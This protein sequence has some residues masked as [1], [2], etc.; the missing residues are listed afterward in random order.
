MTLDWWIEATVK[1]VVVFLSVLIASVYLMWVER[2][3]V[4][5]IQSRIG[6]NRVGPQGLLQPIADVIKLITKETVH[7]EA[8]DRRLFL[9]APVFTLVPTFLAF[10]VIP[11]G[12]AITLLGREIQMRPADINV[13]VLLVL[14]LG[15]IGIYGIFLGAWS[16]NNKYALMGGLRTSAQMIS[17]ELIL[18]LAVIAVVIHSGSF[19]LVEIVNAQSKF[20]FV[21]YQ[22]RG[23]A[24]FIIASMAEINRVPFDLPEAE[25]ELVAGYHTEYNGL[26]FGFFFLS[27]YANVIRVSVV[28][29]LLFLGGWQVP[30]PSPTWLA[31]LWLMVKLA[32]LIFFLMW[33]RAT[34][35]RLRFDQL[36]QFGWK[37]MLPLG[38]LNIIATA[39][40][41]ALLA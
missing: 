40:V 33:T 31:P 38:L 17:Y 20:W 8:A 4:A 37:V 9:I 27:E 16:S 30:W 15:S 12:E 7:P 5:H 35:P 29:T 41:V 36:M 34:L 25:T 24:L 32:I 21:V 39:F 22:P 13:A 10:S 6:P 1:G 2:R 23:F 18:S 3:V 28:A 14:A 26:R 11:I 19:S